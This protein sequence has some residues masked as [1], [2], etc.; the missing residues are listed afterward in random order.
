MEN[1]T[2]PNNTDYPFLDQDPKALVGYLLSS[3]VK[4]SSFV[5]SS[6]WDGLFMRAYRAYYSQSTSRNHTIGT[7][8]DQDEFQSIQINHLR[9]LLTHIMSQVTQNRISFDAVTNSTDVNARN[10]AIVANA[11]LEQYIYAHGLEAQLK[12]CLEI[13]LLFGTS[14]LFTEWA[15]DKKLAGVD[16]DGNPVYHGE[17]KL[18]AL[19]PFDCFAEPFR[20]NWDTQNWVVVREQINKYDLAA[21]YP[22]ARE[23]ILTLP[24]ISDLQRFMP[25]YTYDSHTVWV[26]KAYHKPTPAL[27]N[28]R[29]TVFAQNDVVLMDQFQNP[30]GCLPVLCYRPA[31]KFGGI[32]GHS[33]LFDLMPIQD[34]L[35][36]VDSSMITIA[37][38]F[39]IPNMVASKRSN[40]DASLLS[41]GMRLLEIDPD[42]DF[43][44]GGIPQPMKMPEISQSLV[45]YRE[46]L[47]K[48]MET[49]SGVNPVSRG[50]TSS[51]SSGTALAVATSASQVYNST[52]ENGYTRLVEGAAMQ[53]I[54]LCKNFMQTEEVLAI[55]GQSRMFMVSSF[56]GDTLEPV[57]RIKITIGNPLAKNL[58]GRLEIANQ[59]LGQGMIK[60]NEY[61]E[62]LQTGNINN[63]LDAA[64]QDAAYILL[65]NEELARGEEV[66][67][68]VLDSHQDHIQGHKAL[69]LRPDIRKDSKIVGLVMEHISQHLDTMIKL[70]NENPML[71]SL[72]ANQPVQLPTPSAPGFGQTPPP[73]GVQPPPGAGPQGAP[74]PNPT[75]IANVEAPGG[76]QA[77]AAKGEQEGQA[78]QDQSD[79]AAQSGGQ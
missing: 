14:F 79:Q 8:G 38:N 74:P 1:G 61:L 22:E 34:A 58:A 72:S 10:S 52:I 70:S 65:E 55:S 12:N 6:Q 40:I 60:P 24:K 42:P 45:N 27:P 49:I 36:M 56:T 29:Y 2:T 33:P 75:S 54:N 28:G 17:P 77:L 4:W 31:V 20:D 44:G 48:D 37:N 35:N 53:L 57:Q 18:Q 39:S 30:Y 68:S 73:G 25:F 76:V 50:N 11:V 59:L 13:G 32:Y 26:Y 19:T 71:L 15:L 16:G 63:V 41:G 62:V 47:T 5:H 67:M 3:W 43:P 21:M 51:L 69:L 64:T 66:I 9:N 23:E 7:L 46:M 78:L